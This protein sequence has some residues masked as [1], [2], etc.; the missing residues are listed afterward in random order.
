MVPPVNAPATS[1]PI[2]VLGAGS[3][4]TALALS[5]A[6][7]QQQVK[8]WGHDRAVLATLEREREN[9]RYLP[10]ITFPDTLQV[11]PDLAQALTHANDVLVVV[12]S[13]AFRK[14]LQQLAP[15]W[16]SDLRLVWATKGLD[17]HTHQLLHAVVQEVLG[18]GVKMAVLSGPN[19]AKEVAAGLPTATTLACV[20]KAFAADLVARLHSQ[21]LRVYT[22]NDMIGVQLGGAVK[23]VLAIATGIADGLG[24]G[25]NARAA[26][27]T[28]GLSEIMRLG[29]ALGGKQETFMGL[30]GLGDLVLTCTDNQSRNR[31]FGLA[32]GQG[33]S[34]QQA[35]K[36]IGQV[37]EGKDNAA[38]VFEL[39]QQH[40]IDMPIVEQVFR[41]LHQG[42][43]PQNAVTNLMARAPKAE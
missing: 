2:T 26:L 38:Q 17:P 36:E 4:G 40:K 29:L 7:N 8:L 27:I 23:N 41:V 15:H 31:R 1:S 3:W 10:G 35:E 6:N 18:E 34:A 39:A 13:H 5:L 21:S 20:D 33:K 22:S 37:V 19:F 32:L 9:A 12:P 14:V 11:E 24:C 43:S 25:A 30:A 28:R 42:I 16:R